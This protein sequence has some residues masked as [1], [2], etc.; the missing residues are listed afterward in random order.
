MGFSG[1]ASVSE[2]NSTF[3]VLFVGF[4][5]AV[6]LYGLTFFRTSSEL[7]L[8][9]SSFLPVALTRHDRNLRILRALSKRVPM[10]ETHCE[11]YIKKVSGSC[12]SF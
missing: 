6:S 9:P 4:V 8:L 7:S 12:A 1:P 3:G 5:L 10:D 2:L 11:N